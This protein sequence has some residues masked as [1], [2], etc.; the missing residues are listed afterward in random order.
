MRLLLIHHK[1][2]YVLCLSLQGKQTPLKVRKQPQILGRGYGQLH[3]VYD[4]YLAFQHT[5]T[6]NVCVCVFPQSSVLTLLVLWGFKCL[7]WFKY[8]MAFHSYVLRVLESWSGTPSVLNRVKFGTRDMPLILRLKGNN[9][10]GQ[11][12]CLCSASFGEANQPQPV[13]LLSTYAH[14]SP[15]LCPYLSQKRFN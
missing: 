14:L 10:S 9:N 6:S 15:L 11:L 8:L 4:S 12:W 5:K 1:D 3:L 7:L 13:C 2:V